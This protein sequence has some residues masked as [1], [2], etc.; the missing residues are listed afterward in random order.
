MHRGRSIALFVCCSI[1]ATAQAQVHPRLTV[2]TPPGGQAGTSVKVTL[3]GVDLDEVTGLMI[4]PAGLTAQRVPDPAKK[5]QFLPN[6]YEIKIPPDLP[7][8]SFDVRCVNQWGVSNPRTF[9]VGELPEVQEKEPNNDVPQAQ[10]LSLNSTANGAIQSPADVD[11]FSV[12]C[13]KGDH[14]VV[15][16]AAESIDSRL[17]PDLRIFN[18]SN[19]LLAANRPR[20]EPDAVCSWVVP[21]DGIYTI[22]LCSHAHIAGSVESFYRLTVSTRPWIDSVYPPVVELGKATSVTVW[23]RNLPGGVEDP[24]FRMGTQTRQKLVSTL[25]S[26]TDPHAE[27]RLSGLNWVPPYCAGL[28]GFGFRLRNNAGW[29][30]AVPIGFAQGPIVLES[31]DNDT[32]SKAQVVQIP[33]EIV[34]RIE[35]RDDRDWYAFV[36]KAGEVVAIEGYAER[37]GVPIDLYFEVRRAD[38]GAMIGEFDENPDQSSYHRFFSR[39]DD[40]A[41]RFTLPVDGRYEVMVSSRDATLRG[42]PRLVYRMSI[43]RPKPDFR[44]FLIDAL[45]ANP[46]TLCLHPGGR[47]HFDVVVFRRDGF[48]GPISLS[49]EGLPAGVTCQPQQITSGMNTGV[50]V[51]AAAEKVADFTGV[52]TVKATA[53]IEGK[54]VTREVRSGCLVWPNNNE[55]NN[56]AGIGRVA[57]STVLCIRQKQPPFRVS[58]VQEKMAMPLGGNTNLKVKVER[59]WPDA[60][61]PIGLTAV[62]LPPGVAFNNN[63]PLTIP[64]DKSEAEARLQVPGNLAAES[65]SVVMRGSSQ[66]PFN[67]DPMAKQKPN[68]AMYAAS[69]PMQIAVYRRVADVS[70]APAQVVLKQGSDSTVTLKVIRLHDFQ[71]PL[72]VQLQGLPNGVTAANVTIPEKANEVKLLFKAAKNAAEN[73][74]VSVTVRV[75]GNIAPVNLT[76]EAKLNVEVKKQPRVVM[77]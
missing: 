55:P 6:Q 61:Q 23:G 2:L 13:K 27:Q 39:T 58:F 49:V 69:L 18:S 38:N 41:T 64:A 3:T 20:S 37:V 33:A 44:A 32:S 71:G 25:V 35:Q 48:S 51:L 12:S 28:D 22:R 46:S 5:G 42:E 59:L 65:F 45:P 66:I 40:P 19:R 11:Y 52:L 26:P 77:F 72:Q 56:G 76:T 67:K 75:I 31:V 17:E 34:G 47:E 16:V 7:P 4:H 62:H 14:V 54:P 74:M 70:I 60:K 15:S 1:L 73:K 21:S 57:R 8:G 10:A 53:T 43:H 36:G 9:I 50:L 63:Q 24:Q 29:S 68:T 30:N